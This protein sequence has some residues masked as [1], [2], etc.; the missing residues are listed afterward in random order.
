MQMPLSRV[1]Y[2]QIM[3]GK[4]DHPTNSVAEQSTQVSGEVIQEMDLVSRYGLM[5]PSIK[6]NGIITKLVEEVNLHTKMVTFMRGSGKMICVM[7]MV[8]INI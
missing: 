7:V 4:I 5:V 8:Y 3:K 6:E 1:K 2:T